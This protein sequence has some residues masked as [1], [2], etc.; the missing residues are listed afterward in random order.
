ME[1]VKK[2]KK[3]AR[4]VEEIIYVVPEEREEYL[5]THLNP[6]EKIQQIMW[7]HGMRKQFYFYLNDMILM[8]FEYVGKDFHGDMV[9]MMEPPEMKDFLIPKRRRDVPAGE[10]LTTNWWAPLQRIGGA[11]L[12]SPMPDDDMEEIAQEEY[13]HAM[14]GG[15][16]KNGGR[17]EVDLAY[18]ED[19]WSDSI[20]I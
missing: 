6:P 11:L 7:M 9:M 4:R 1:N 15:Y 19:D 5:K 8:S 10:L 16:T 13:Y 18:D 12:E 2:K 20:H 17:E 3:Q 14:L